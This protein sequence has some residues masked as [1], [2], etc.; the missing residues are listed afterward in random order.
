MVEGF[1]QVAQSALE[2]GEVDHHVLVRALHLQ[3]FLLQ[4]GNHTPAVT[5]EILAFAVIVG[6]EMSGIEAALGF[7][8]VH[9][10][11]FHISENH[12]GET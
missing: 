6:E 5:V 3:L 9:R 8:P 4:I 11:P 1:G 12:R 2:V 10:R 7:K